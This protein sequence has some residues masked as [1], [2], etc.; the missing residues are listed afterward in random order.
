MAANKTRDILLSG[1]KAADNA[2]VTV[3][4]R[5]VKE[6][7]GAKADDAMKGAKNRSG[8]HVELNRLGLIEALS[9]VAATPAG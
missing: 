6:V 8:T 4:I 5:H 7:L 1:C 9:G 3:E 2:T